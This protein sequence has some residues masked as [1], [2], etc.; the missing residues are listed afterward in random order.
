MAGK[1]QEY[2]LENSLGHLTARF[3][4][5]IMKQINR[6]FSEAGL[7]ITLEQWPILIYVWEHNGVFQV[8]LAKKLF[9]DK[10]TIARLVAGIEAAGMIARVPNPSDGRGKSVYLTE[11]GKTMMSKATAIVQKLDEIATGGIDEHELKICRDVLRNIHRNL[12][13]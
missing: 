9:K 10:T 13:A 4:R 5:A 12:A 2:V 1:R 3:Y 8:D 7:Q 6:E 11:K